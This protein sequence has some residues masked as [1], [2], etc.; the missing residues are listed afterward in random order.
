MSA[1]P[2]LGEPVPFGPGEPN[3]TIEDVQLQD[4]LLLETDPALPDPH[5]LAVLPVSDAVPIVSTHATDHPLLVAGDGAGLVEAAGAGLIDGTEL[6]RYSASLDEEEIAAALDDGAVLLLTDSNR[7]RGERWTTVRHT[8]GYTEPADSEPL[9]PDLTDNRLPVFPGADEST[10]TL[11]QEQGDVVARASRYGNP[12][13][14][15]S[16]ERA[17]LAVD[18]DVDT[19][20]RTSAFADARGERLELA[21]AE[22]I[23]TD[24]ITFTQPINGG[25]NR[26]LTEV[27]V[28]FDGGSPIDV[29]LG[30]ESRDAPGQRISFSERTFSTVTVEILADTAGD[31]PGFGGL[32]S[33][34][35]AEIAVG[36][37]PPLQRESIALP[38]DMLSAA[39]QDAL[40]HPLAILVTRQRQDPTD[41][42]RRDE[43]E[44]MA[45]AFSLPAEREFALTGDLRLSRRHP[46]YVLDEVLGRTHDGSVTWVRASTELNGGVATPAA[47]FDGDPATFW[48]TVR[49][50]PE[51]QWVE[52][53][54]TEPETVREI[55]LTVVADGLHSVPTEV[56][57][58]V[59]GTSVGRV[60][61][62][63]ITDGT[64]QNSTADVVLPLPEA[65][66]GSTFRLRLTGVRAVTTHDWVADDDVDQPAAIAEIGLPGEKV[67]ALPE[68]FDSGCRDDIVTLDGEPVPVRARGSMAA[69]LAGEP[70]PLT[71]CGRAPVAIDGG[72]HE[73]TTAPGDS[74]GL[75]IDQLVLRSSAGGA[76]APVEGTLLEAATGGEASAGPQVRVLGDGHDHST[77]EVTGAEPGEPF[78]L[79]LGQSHNPGWIATVDGEALGEPDLVDGF[80]NGWLVT[81]D[82]ASFQVE[83]RF[84]PQ[85]RVTAAIVVSVIA[86]LACLLLLIRRPR[87]VVDAPSSLAEPYSSVL[88]FR[89]DGALPTRRTALWTGLGVGLL[90]LVLAGPFVGIVI[91]VVAAVGA[92]HETF[93]RYLLV[94]SPVALALCALYVLYVQARW[95]PPP[96]FDWPIEMRRPH[97]IGWLAV[98]LLV[99]DV[100]V[101]RVWQSR[102]SDDG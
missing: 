27:R 57:V 100:I 97:P 39:G 44:F 4:E 61:V 64:V 1:A 67:P 29:D 21:F 58:L 63:P 13:T 52:V 53:N 42:T 69:A 35:F 55:P 82:A 80:A 60:P 86:A 34:G 3:L 68:R 45:R 51:R 74:T 49:S 7:R 11:A 71:T 98:L 15:T 70:L 38:T 62:P 20:W 83:L 23:T 12:I 85:G 77:V 40:D 93:R 89:Y 79:V 76:A 28:T 47:A 37:Q 14:Y 33:V 48:T 2:G 102:R 56:E 26:F 41:T 72:D 24:R 22:P 59:D 96:F 65:V 8:R 88:A 99:T 101:D 73:L 9:E 43:E 78:W 81:P 90:G 5:E 87:P 32:S 36:D 10:M 25:R 46:S 6:I 30:V 66:T 92:R 19:A 95:S 31:I 91:G 17:A 54:L 84:A 16:E 94:A 50:T 75:D 18:G